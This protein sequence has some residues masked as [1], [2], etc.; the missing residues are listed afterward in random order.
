VA[1]GRLTGSYFID[2]ETAIGQNRSSSLKS[3]WLAFSSANA[4]RTPAASVAGLL[5]FPSIFH[6]ICF[7]FEASPFRAM[8]A[9]TGL[10]ACR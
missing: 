4:C 8:G 5:N 6:V 10:K 1:G 3:S 2:G 9:D 7:W